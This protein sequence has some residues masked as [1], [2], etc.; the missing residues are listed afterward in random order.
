MKY[1]AT[2]KLWKSDKEVEVHCVVRDS[3]PLAVKEFDRLG[4]LDDS[5]RN[6]VRFHL[7]NGMLPGETMMVWA[8]DVGTGHIE[9]TTED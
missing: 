8:P 5:E 1:I 7:E 4:R 6:Y 2:V 3:L 9:T